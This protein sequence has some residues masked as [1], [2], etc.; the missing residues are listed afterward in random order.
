MKDIKKI[1]VLVVDDSAYNRKMIKSM[2]LEMDEV[3]SVSVSSDGEEAIKHILADQPQVI[4]LDLNMP[5][6][7]GFTFLRWL[8]KHNPLPVVVVSAEGGEKNVFRALD[9]GALDFVVKPVRYASERIVD[10]KPELQEKVRAVADMDLGLYL[11]R[12]RRTKPEATRAVSPR[13]EVEGK[14]QGVVVIG[15]STGGPSA[16]QKVLSDLPPDLPYSFV[17][18]QHM[19]PVFTAQFAKRLEKN[20]SF[21]AKEAEDG[22]T[23]AP[24]QIYVAPGG[25]HLEVRKIKTGRLAVKERGNE[26]RYV[27]SIDMA[28]SSAARSF[29][30]S[31]VGVLLTGMGNDGANGMLEI[32]NAGG[33]TIV[34]S[35]KT[36]VI[37]G[38]PRA[39]IGKNA[40]GSIVDLEGISGKLLEVLKGN[41]ILKKARSDDTKK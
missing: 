24:G 4:T 28:M 38:M 23:L 21:I 17:V 2:V 20:T 36:A 13:P 39:A 16:V 26:D 25:F 29:G 35:E 11:S 18:V 34:E 14:L 7:D 37:F 27:P 31:A 1:K 5:R 22:D 33:K 8:M 40:A 9:L 3:E 15:A 6:M 19:P 41:S 30:G 32:V 12:L 10:I